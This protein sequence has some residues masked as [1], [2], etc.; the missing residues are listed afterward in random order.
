MSIGFPVVGVMERR[1][2]LHRRDDGAC[3]GGD[4]VHD[5]SASSRPLRDWPPHAGEYIGA[6]AA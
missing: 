3:G 5:F 2:P 6:G 1:E 4:H